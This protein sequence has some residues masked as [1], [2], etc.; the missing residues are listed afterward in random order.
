VVE[1]DPLPNPAGGSTRSGVEH[2]LIRVFCLMRSALVLPSSY[3]V[4]VRSVATGVSRGIVLALLA[5]IAVESLAL[6]TWL[7]RLG[8]L[9]ASRLPWV[10]DL[11]VMIP[12][13]VAAA[14]VTPADERQAPWSTGV[15][16]V[17]MSTAAL[18]AL[19]TPSLALALLCGSALAV[20]H[21][22]S[23]A[24]PFACPF[25]M[26]V[27]ACTGALA[28]PLASALT[29][30]FAWVTRNLADEAD[31][32]L[33]RV[34]V[35]ERERGRAT[36]HDLLPLLKPASGSGN[37]VRRP[38]A[39]GEASTVYHRMR[40]FVDGADQPLPGR[41]SRIRPV[42]TRSDAE[43][44]L[45]FGFVVC[46]ALCVVMVLAGTAIISLVS[47]PPG[48]TA[49]AVLVAVAVE[50]A[51]VGH[52]LNRSGDVR[53][54][55]W[56]AW[57]DLFTGMVVL[58]VVMVSFPPGSR[59]STWY[60]WVFNIPL[61]AT[62][63]VATTV[64]PLRRIVMI[65]L[66]LGLVHSALFMI[67]AWNR[68]D[69]IVA[70]AGDSWEYLG[71]ALS[72]WLFATTIRQLATVADTA[73]DRVA[74][75]ERERNRARVHDVLPYLSPAARAETDTA[76]RTVLER[77]ARA[78]YLQLKAYVDGVPLSEDLGSRLQGVLE[79]HPRL[80]PR[81]ELDLELDLDLGLPEEVLDR[82]VRAVDTALANA[83]QNAPGAAVVLTA[84]CDPGSVTV[85]VRDDG[86]GFD[87]AGTL[88][89][90]GITRI[91]GTHLDEVGGRGTV[92][93]APSRG[94]QV[95][96]VVPRGAV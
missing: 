64:R 20:A 48:P 80:I 70:T 88:L 12:C 33:R 39:A 24:T 66:G 58:V 32:A 26:V 30:S 54:E 96:V 42:S 44:M 81:T 75:L 60:L 87:V 5:G 17:A 14:L 22:L 91:L 90:Y 9:T 3:A 76:V 61:S 35:L 79:L 10:L 68:R 94:T 50:S 2:A 59:P 51:V 86:P 1:G 65:G 38:F 84:T 72:V 4:L 34:A 47:P 92:R 19:S 31:E 37:G 73:R 11:S 18:V 52:R 56:L 36:I 49:T 8:S 69:L 53:A 71:V 93:S 15:F 28:F 16:V 13:L 77:Q 6:G 46:R 21:V 63:F 62:G 40:A 29:W 85:T 82:L 83:E 25:S 67:L 43:W 55:Q 23:E 95:T 41:A 27:T 74:Q 45:A 7:R 89:G 78:K 57:A